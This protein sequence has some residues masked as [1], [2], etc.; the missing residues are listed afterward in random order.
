MQDVE[1]NNFIILDALG[2]LYVMYH[3]LIV[4]TLLNSNHF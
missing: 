1:N 3:N 4:I 2:N